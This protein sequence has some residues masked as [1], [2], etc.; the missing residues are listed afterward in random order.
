M[1]RLRPFLRFFL[2]LAVFLIP[3]T[4][5]TMQETENGITMEITGV[6]STQMPTVIITANVLNSAR[7]PVRGLGAQDFVLSG[8]LGERGRIVRVENI[9]DEDLTYAVALVID[10]SSS[11]AGA[12]IERAKEAAR[13]FV[14][15]IGADDPVAILTFDNEVRLVQDYTSDKALLLAAINAL[16]FG[17]QTALYEAGLR[18]V[19]LAAQA[20]V[21]RRAMILLSDGAE[22][23]GAS[24]AARSDALAAAARLGVSAYTIGLGYGIDRSY[25]QDLAA[26]TNARFYESP[27]PAELEA[28]YTDLANLFR[29]LYVIT[30]EVDVPLDG[31]NYVVG[32]QANTEE[33]PSEVDASIVRAP[34][35][36]PLVQLPDPLFAEPLSEIARV[37]PNIAADDPIVSVE[38]RLNGVD[39]PF[40]GD[41]LVFD[42]VA[43]QP[44][45]YTLDIRAIDADGDGGVAQRQFEV[46]ALPS[47]IALSSNFALPLSEPLELGVGATGQTAAAEVVFSIDGEEVARQ[48][49]APFSLLIDPF[50]LSPGAHA[51]N[52]TVTNEGGVASSVALDFEVAALSP[53]ILRIVGVEADE[54]VDTPRLVSVET[55]T[56][57]GTNVNSLS[58]T[59]NG[60]ALTEPS[61]DPFFFAPG[62]ARLEATVGADNGTSSSAE[63]AFEIAA[64]P[65]RLDL[66]ASSG[67]ITV[68]GEI[69]FSVASQTAINTLSAR[70]EE[71]PGVRLTIS[72]DA[73]RV[74]AID[75][76]ALGDGEYTLTITVRDR[77]DLET[78]ASTSFRVV[79]PTPTPNVPETETAAAII[80]QMTADFVATSDAAATQSARA[81]EEANATGTAIAVGTL[82]ANSTATAIIELTAT[83]E[84]EINATGT[85]EIQAQ[86][87]ANLFATATERA[88][89]NA[90]AVTEE[91]SATPEAPTETVTPEPATDTP[92]PPTDTVVPPTDTVVPPTDTVV[93]PTDT[94]VPPTETASPEPTA[95]PDLGATSTLQAQNRA[96]LFASATV[97]AELNAAN[98]AATADAQG[99]SEAAEAA[100]NAQATADAIATANA[101]GTSEAGAAAANAQ[102]TSDANATLT[103]TMAIESTAT[104]SPTDEPTATTTPTE[105]P[106]TPTATPEA[107]TETPTQRLTPTPSRIVEVPAQEAPPIEGN[108]SLLLCGLGLAV[109]LVIVLLIL[110]S[111]RKPQS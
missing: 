43:L 87:R 5:A 20:P 81:E 40:V 28:I 60:T 29:S 18:G 4:W 30:L 108:L 65:P 22:F 10:T 111:R 110:R 103:A 94:V 85:A 23:G 36:V 15:A 104:T 16:P 63:M 13:L 62:D 80:A 56:Q 84:F 75:G 46:A 69:V 98:A 82:A 68:R 50:L 99:T 34:I 107:P 73:P 74:V 21:E 105:E 78:S 89:L 76:A 96:N 71:Q 100:A 92:V 109:L 24:Q 6:N 106:A 91:P 25:L 79:L 52:V 64:L 57:A 2:L 19:E 44:G 101:L 61:F 7:L 102:S 9:T 88:L 32:L 33:G 38:A 3:F 72:G 14:N 54:T 1:R 47:T 97:R 86:N 90:S 59:L 48:I 31:T 67:I 45:T 27:T 41:T 8:E 66:P 17:G 55:A 39:F 58:F 49:E 93:P 26:G 37:V 70:I 35:P 12:P 11:M 77:S 95:T 51:L 42:P 83:R 53:R